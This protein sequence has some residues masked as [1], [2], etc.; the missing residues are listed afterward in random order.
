MQSVRTERPEDR[1]LVSGMSAALLLAA[2]KRREAEVEYFATLTAW[3]EAGYGDTPFEGDSL[4]SLVSLYGEEQRFDEAR[5]VLDRALAI[6]ARS[7]D[8]VPMD[9]AK[10]LSI[11]AALHAQL[12]E[13]REAEREFADALSIVGS[14]PHVDS[15]V[16]ATVLTNYPQILRKTHRRR[17]ARSIE[18]RASLLRRDHASNAV[19]DVTDLL[20]KEKPKKN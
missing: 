11:Q 18:A 6:F 5:Q 19:V 7:K 10:L 8:T 12:G 17:E 3:R 15:T 16:I 20:A 2:G 14:E 13:L 1:A 9:R 4:L